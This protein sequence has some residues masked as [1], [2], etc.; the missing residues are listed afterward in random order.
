MKYVYQGITLSLFIILNSACSPPMM[1]SSAAFNWSFLTGAPTSQLEKT[2]TLTDQ[3]PN[4]V[5]M[6]FV[7]DN[8]YS[9]GPYHTALANSFNSFIQQFST[10]GIN[11]QIGV[12]TTSVSTSGINGDGEYYVGIEKNMYTNNGTTCPTSYTGAICNSNGF[13]FNTGHNN[14]GNLLIRGN[15]LSALPAGQHFFTNTT[16]NLNTLF[17]EVITGVGLNGAG[18][19]TV[20]KSTIQ[21]LQT[22]KIS[23][24]GWN[25]NFIRNKA[26]LVLFLLTDEDEADNE[27]TGGPY[28]SPIQKT[29][30]QWNS[31]RTVCT[32]YTNTSQFTTRCLEK[33]TQNVCTKWNNEGPYSSVNPPSGATERLP[34]IALDTRT[35]LEAVKPNNR[36]FTRYLVNKSKLQTNITN[37]NGIYPRFINDA[38]GTPIL[39][40][41]SASESTLLKGPVIDICEKNAAGQCK[42]Y[43]QQ[44]IENASSIISNIQSVYM[45]DLQPVAP[46]NKDKFKVY[47]NDQ[48][49]PQDLNNGWTYKDEGFTVVLHGA[50]APPAIS[51]TMKVVYDAYKPQ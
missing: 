37:A 50:Y 20:L 49:I 30:V 2:F 31:A 26:A 27:A 39:L 19:E 41:I 35:R 16:P 17:S 1:D 51:G 32:K 3:D 36:F 45:L 29:C 28:D 21:T 4:A 12:V 43:G 14:T 13:V 8:S 10:L 34:K 42:D 5:D 46:S 38:G 15:A 44:L 24:T 18:G 40:G 22:S 9:M 48:L 25:K 6:L 47:I 11:F 7:I 23:S 33:D